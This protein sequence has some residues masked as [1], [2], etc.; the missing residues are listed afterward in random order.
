MIISKDQ[1]I[2][3]LGVP[4]T[5]TK[6]ISKV[7][8]PYGTKLLE[9]GNYFRSIFYGI[10][11]IENF[12]HL[13]IQRVYVFWRDPVERFISGVNFTRSKSIT[14]TL[15]RNYPYLFGPTKLDLSPYESPHISPLSKNDP[16]L[17]IPK[18]IVDICYEFAQTITPEKMFKCKPLLMNNMIFRKQ[19]FWHIPKPKGEFIVLDFAN[20]EENLKR[21]AIDFG[22]PSNVIIPRINESDHITTS[23]SPDLEAAVKQYYAEDYTLKPD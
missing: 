8:E 12:D 17:K 14:E 21:V 5:G 19:A 23:L 18:E 20:F 7:I 10:R 4:K 9:H 11:N 3:F 6:S 1:K 13:K 2:L 15:I 22:A 16:S